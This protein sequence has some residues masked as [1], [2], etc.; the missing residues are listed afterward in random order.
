MNEQREA[1]YNAHIEW[2]STQEQVD[3]ICVI[4]VRV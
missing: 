4:G 1:L 3:D 2:R